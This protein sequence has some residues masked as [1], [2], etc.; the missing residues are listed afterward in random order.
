MAGFYL[1]II[2]GN[3]GHILRKK[4]ASAIPR[5]GDEIRLGD[6]RFYEVIQVVWVY[7]ELF[8][9]LERVNIGVVPV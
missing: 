1:H 8:R 2:D 6:D 4:Q 9:N 5:A 7:D 3:D